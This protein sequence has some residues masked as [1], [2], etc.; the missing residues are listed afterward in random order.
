MKTDGSR[1]D[2]L[3]C[4]LLC[5][6]VTN[7]DD[8][9][10]Y[11]TPCVSWKDWN[12]VELQNEQRWGRSLWLSWS[13]CNW[14]RGRGDWNATRPRP[15]LTLCWSSHVS[16]PTWRSSNTLVLW[17]EPWKWTVLVFCFWSRRRRGLLICWR[18]SSTESSISL[19]V[20][21]LLFQNY[22][23]RNSLPPNVTSART[24]TVF[25]NRLKSD[26]FPIMSFLLSISLVLRTV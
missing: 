25:R 14:R 12:N 17:A 1:A 9:I 8:S 2:K 4:I 24:I 10:I 18:I 15:W 6:I 19:F 21:S 23:T 26:L 5:V 20:I 11:P 7:T 3:H 22:C 16:P 13:E